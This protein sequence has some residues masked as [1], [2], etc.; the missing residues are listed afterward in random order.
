MQFS[1]NTSMRIKAR[2]LS[3]SACLALAAGT[4][5]GQTSG[6]PRFDVA[7][8]KPSALDMMK[9]AAQI[10]STGQM[11]KIGAHVDGTRA[12]YLFMG[13][14][15]LIAEAYRVRPF[16]ITGPDWLNNAAGQRF[17]IEAKMPDGSTKN[18]A[19]MMLRALLAERFKLA[20]HLDT[21]EHPV[22]ALVVAKGGPKLHESPAVPA[23]D[24]DDNTP[25][26]PGESQ[27]ET[28][29][30]PM[31]MTVDSK[32]GSS[33]VNMGQRGV[34][35]Q[36]MGSNGTFQ[37][38]G[39]GAMMSAFAD[40]LTQMTQLTG[41]G[42]VQV[43]DMTGLKGHYEVALEFPLAD[44]MKMVQSLGFGPGG[45]GGAAG[46][47]PSAAASDPGGSTSVL[48]AVSI[49]GLKLEKRK[50]PTEQLIIDHVEKMPTEN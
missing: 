5:F 39:K 25:L 37:I 12:E 10:Q 15:E 42:G 28:P 3:V 32:N 2:L 21:K 6:S 7:S 17:D 13:V 1:F 19:P 9:L 8:V 43:V 24:F 31:R 33:V 20:A 23:Q 48:D 45:D 14:K 16:Q 11:P 4:G 40:M 47:L 46:G 35:T 34:W 36:K 29:Q 50:A 49:L 26:K 44:L 27:M 18:Q 38:E 30:G 22:L 41:G